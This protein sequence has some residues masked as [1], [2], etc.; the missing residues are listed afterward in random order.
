MGTD[1]GVWIPS[2][3]DKQVEVDFTDYAN[4]Q[5][6]E[7]FDLYMEVAED[8]QNTEALKELYCDYNVG[9]IFFGSRKS[10]SDSM[11]REELEGSVYFE[12]IFD[13]GASIF[14]IKAQECG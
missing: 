8:S 9:Y 5:S 14:M 7:V 11:Q 10:P 4:P 3:T 1:S 12:K 6:N 13:N 2:F